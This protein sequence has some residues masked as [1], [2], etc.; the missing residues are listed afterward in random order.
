MNRKEGLI[1]ST[2]FLFERKEA[3]IQ[4]YTALAKNDFPTC[5]VKSFRYAYLSQNEHHTLKPFY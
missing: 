5:S 2:S 3:K 4:G 1:Y